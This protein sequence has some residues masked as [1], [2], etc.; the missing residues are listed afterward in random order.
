[1]KKLLILLCLIVASKSFATDL[2]V[3]PTG[4]D[5]SNGTLEQPFKT[6]EKAKNA[7]RKYNDHVTIYFRDGVYRIKETIVFNIPDGNTTYRAYKDEEP[8]ITSGVPVANWLKLSVYP[9]GIH[10]NAKGNLWVAD[11]PE[12]V[13]DF[14]VL[15][16]N[17]QM[18]QRAHSRGFQTPEAKFKKLATRNVAR[19]EDFDLL[20]TLPFPNDEIKDWDNIEDVEVYFCGVPWTQNIIP[21]VKVDTKNR[22]ATLAF[23]G[24]TPPSTTP[25]SYNPTYIENIIDVLDT[26]GEWCV[27]TKTRK[28]YYW[29]I[30]GTPSTKIE[31]PTL[32]EFFRVEGEIDFKAA[33]DVPVKNINFVGLTFTKGDRYSWWKGHKGWGIQH[34]WDKFDHGNSLLRFRGAEDCLVSECAFVNSG[35]SAIRLDLHAQNITIENSLIDRVGHMG[36]LL[37]GYGPGTKDVN[38]N[39]KIVNNIIRRV[40]EVIW[41]GHAIFVW[42]SGNNHIANNHIRETPRKAIGICGVR[43]AIFQNG[44]H[45]DWDEAAKTIRWKELKYQSYTKGNKT[46]E[47]I[48]PYLHSRNNLVENNYIYRTRTKIGDGASLNVSGAGTGNV[49]KRNMLY[50]SLGNGMR[51]DDWQNGTTFEE[52]LILSGGV[53]HKGKNDLLNNIFVNSNIR[54]SFYP[55]QQPNPG[56]QVKGNVFYATRYVVPYVGRSSKNMSTPDIC[57]VENNIY[58]VEG[59]SDKLQA[60]KKEQES[61]GVDIG[62]IVAN[63]GFANVI[64]LKKELHPSDFNLKS[65]GAAVQL[66]VPQID[67]SSIGLTKSYPTEFLSAVFP[68]HNG[69]LISENAKVSTNAKANS[70]NLQNLVKSNKSNLER[71]IQIKGEET[72]Y[73]QLELDKSYT[74]NGLKLIADYKDRNNSMRGLTVWTSENGEDWNQIWQVDPYHIAMGRDWLIKTNTPVQAK[75]IRVGLRSNDLVQLAA[76]DDRGKSLKEQL[77][78][79]NSI[80]VY[81]K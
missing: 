38:K 4:N 50:M 12:G 26:P 39:N 6:I 7:A 27:N 30:N 54:F 52:N 37:C 68:E 53:V 76:H 10:E 62:S 9:V 43:G 24:N 14:K 79:L 42:Q 40:G 13:T 75:Y 74:I 63:P 66:G 81:G 41:H 22:V 5:A 46:Q 3:S 2:Y 45:V 34:D 56:S 65:D 70:G 80:F 29:P 57:D 1:M 32:I 73:V 71:V 20:K 61:N 21:L 17:N 23:A 59:G 67:F 18:L 44:K 25:K 15:F 28:I 33:K 11:I 64:D 55:D 19:K 49:M 77:F 60:F 8:I 51:C 31:A 16:D 36:I 72:P 47:K 35:N 48:L 69:L 58:Y 78:Y